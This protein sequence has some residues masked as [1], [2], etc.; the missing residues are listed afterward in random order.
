MIQ[1]IRVYRVAVENANAFV[2][3]MRDANLWRE[4]SRHMPPGLIA[5]DLLRS[6][7]LGSL[8]ISIEFWHSEEAYREAQ[9]SAEYAMFIR[10][11]NELTLATYD[12][13]TFSF[14]PGVEN[15]EFERV[16][17]AAGRCR[18]EEA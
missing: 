10:L 4:L 1:C 6:R 18:P 15:Q 3:A 17:P 9:R 2:A 8:Y 14:P 13:G 7:A 5:A 11:L 12:L 16:P